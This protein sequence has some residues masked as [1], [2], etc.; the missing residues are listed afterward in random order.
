MIDSLKKDKLIDR[1]YFRFVLQILTVQEELRK[2]GRLETDLVNRWQRVLNQIDLVTYKKGEF[3][4]FAKKKK[5]ITRVKELLNEDRSLK[6][7][8]DLGNLFGYPNC[9]I[10][11]F[12]KNIDLMIK[13][14][15]F[16]LR[17]KTITQHSQNNFSWLMN[18][19]T[20]FPLILHNNC[21][22]NCQ[23]SINLAKK[24]S[25]LIKSFNKDIHKKIKSEN[26]GVLVID[27]RKEKH[28]FFTNFNLVNKKIVVEDD[29]RKKTYFNTSDPDLKIYRFRE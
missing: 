4:Y 10:E 23:K 27:E 8:K 6:L 21:A 11:H 17:K 16:L 19:F 3:V 2:L 14:E 28:S 5:I 22:Y 29:N 20:D 12:I 25:Q 24:H 15:D 13:E 26:I 7:N 18:N 9:C 1:D